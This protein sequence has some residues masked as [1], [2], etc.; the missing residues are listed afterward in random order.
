MHIIDTF[1]QT[2]SRWGMTPTEGGFALFMGFAFLS[3]VQA[4]LMPSVYPFTKLTTDFLLMAICVPLLVF[5]YRRHADARLLYWVLVTYIGTFFI[6]VAGVATG[7]IF[8]VYHYGATMWIQ[9]LGVPLVIA[10]NWTLLILATNQIASHWVRLPIGRAVL[11]AL[12]IAAYDYCIEPVAIQL[13]Y[14][15]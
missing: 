3:G 11:A 7:R 12:L 10:L 6:E 15:Q 8:G 1:R 13:D 4:H 2:A 9:W 5:M 14:W